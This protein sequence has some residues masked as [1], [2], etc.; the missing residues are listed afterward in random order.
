M[1]SN[2]T[3]RNSRQLEPA[4]ALV[5]LLTLHPELPHVDWTVPED[6]A[7]LNGRLWDAPADAMDAFVAALGGEIHDPWT[8]P[9]TG[10]VHQTMTVAFQDVPVTIT[11]YSPAR[12]L[13]AVAA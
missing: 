6:A 11:V 2:P 9:K 10:R 3:H 5:Q 8:N 1:T 12:I 13:S 7:S 4:L